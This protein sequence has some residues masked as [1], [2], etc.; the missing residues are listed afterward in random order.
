MKINPINVSF[1]GRKNNLSEVKAL[2]NLELDGV[3]VTPCHRA[4]GNYNLERTPSNRDEFIMS[5]TKMASDYAEKEAEENPNISFDDAF[6]DKMLALIEY[7]NKAKEDQRDIVEPHVYKIA[8]CAGNQEVEP[9]VFEEKG[10]VD[11]RD[12]ADIV[13]VKDTREKV[14]TALSDLTP[15]EKYVITRRYGFDGEGE[16]TYEEI[17]NEFDVTREKIRQ[18]EAK[19]LRRL[20][21]P[22][23]SR[24]LHDLLHSINDLD[25]DTPLDFDESEDIL[26]GISDLD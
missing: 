19:A 14:K 2:Q 7:A 6:Q 23:R 12:L 18:I 13:C 26:F 16:R 17:A 1:M 4:V 3:D 15:R 21:H 11:S 24:E 25:M 9:D 10:S 20:R 8:R 5:C 22:S